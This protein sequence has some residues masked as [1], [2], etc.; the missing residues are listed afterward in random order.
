MLTRTLMFQLNTER[1]EEIPT[2]P[3]T[4]KDTERVAIDPATSTIQVWKLDKYFL[5]FGTWIINSEP[6]INLFQL[7]TEMPEQI[8]IDPAT[9]KENERA[10]TAVAE[11][12]STRGEDGIGQMVTLQKWN[13][14]MRVIVH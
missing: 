8:P 4:M 1:A 12:V 11:Q 14:K 9:V 13:L 6:W 10:D 7:N 5:V 2:D 3:P